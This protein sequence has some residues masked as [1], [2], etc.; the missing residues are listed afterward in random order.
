MKPQTEVLR[1]THLLIGTVLYRPYVYVFLALS[2][3]LSFY[4]LGKRQTLIQ[5]LVTYLIAFVS[6]WSSTRTGIPFGYYSYFDSSRSRELWIR[7]I[8]FWDSL[9]FVFLLYLSWNL[10]AVLRA[11]SLS[12]GYV[13]KSLSSPKTCFLS[14][15]L[16]LLL[17]VVIDPLTLRG[18]KWFLGR[19]YNYPSGGFYF[20]VTMTNFVGWWLVGFSTSWLQSRIMPPRI[21]R[22]SR[23]WAWGILSMYSGIFLFNLGITAWIGE[24]R[25][26]SASAAL[27]TVVLFWIT[28]RLK[29]NL[30]LEIA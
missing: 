23:N 6:E 12:K 22:S 8:P 9:S 14:G 25:L 28:S 3:A 11:P 19:L 2:L 21:H 20:G 5:T 29:R 1:F 10:A 26:F 18:E 15:L 24:W 30:A 27:T 16:M 17:D 13:E 7:N 4:Q